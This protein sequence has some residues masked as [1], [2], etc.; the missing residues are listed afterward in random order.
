MGKQIKLPYFYDTTNNNVGSLS[1]I[2]GRNYDVSN[3]HLSTVKTVLN[4]SFDDIKSLANSVFINKWAAFRPHGIYEYG[5]YFD[6]QGELQRDY[7]S[8]A[9]GGWRL[10]DFGG[11]N[12]NAVKPQ[13]ETREIIVSQGVD[14]FTI[15]INMGEIAP[16]DIDP[17]I[18]HVYVFQGTVKVATLPILNVI[19]QMRLIEIQVSGQ[20]INDVWK[21][22]TVWYGWEG[23]ERKYRFRFE[24][25]EVYD[26]VS[27]KA[28]P[29]I[30]WLSTEIDNNNHDTETIGSFEYSNT[31]YVY[32]NEVD[33]LNEIHVDVKLLLTSGAYSNSKKY[34][35]YY[36]KTQLPL[37]TDF[38]YDITQAE[39]MTTI[40][41]NGS[42]SL[43][44]ILV[45]YADFPPVGT[46][47]Y[48]YFDETL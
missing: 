15:R 26:T 47:Y 25:E 48:L 31:R 35:V 34:N 46:N 17:N 24:S 44:K 27:V 4:S 16:W 41:T 37:K 45:G 14:N 30:N 20:Y 36:S 2:S 8:S 29:L 6:L 7:P 40:I 18:T 3:I 32:G 21:D 10:G 38:S 28:L 33:V 39:G 5:Y 11:Y 42:N 12:H 19:P 1:Q 22:Y 43:L 13:I 23:N 9:T